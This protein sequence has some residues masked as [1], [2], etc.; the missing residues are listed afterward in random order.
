MALEESGELVALDQSGES[1]YLSY[2]LGAGF[3]EWLSIYEVDD[4]VPDVGPAL[5]PLS[6]HLLI[7]K[8]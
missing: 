1:T 8:S 5:Q 2:F 3:V 7:Q 4:L 6:T